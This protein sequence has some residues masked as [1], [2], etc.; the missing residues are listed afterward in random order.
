VGTD[1]DN[2]RNFEHSRL[3]EEGIENS[4]D[5]LHVDAPAI[6]LRV[7]AHDQ[8]LGLQHLEVVGQQVARDLQG[9]RQDIGG[10]ILDAQ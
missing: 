3:R 9:G 5:R 10:E 8:S 7:R 6:A 1:E 4:V 2:A